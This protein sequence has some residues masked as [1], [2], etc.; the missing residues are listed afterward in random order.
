[1]VNHPSPDYAV[2]QEGIESLRE[3]LSLVVANTKREMQGKPA[4]TTREEKL[5]QAHV[6]RVLGRKP[7]PSELARVRQY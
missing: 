7:E 3:L 6:E 5:L 2:K 1:M 4:N